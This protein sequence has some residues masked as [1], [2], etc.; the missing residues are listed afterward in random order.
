M[1]NSIKILKK[2]SYLVLAATLVFSMF[3][4]TLHHHNDFQTHDNCVFCKA[5]H[6]VHSVDYQ[7]QINWV[8]YIGE[9]A[10]PLIVSVQNNKVPAV[11]SYSPSTSPPFS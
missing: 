3:F 10:F 11:L 5:K 9:I 6:P 8:E 1:E 4:L 7:P 2:T